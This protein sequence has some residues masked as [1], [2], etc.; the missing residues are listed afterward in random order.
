[1]TKRDA[2]NAW[3]SAGG[4]F[5]THEVAPPDAAYSSDDTQY[6]LF[7]ITDLVRRWYTGASPNHGVLFK[8]A[9]AGDYSNDVVEMERLR[10]VVTYLE[11]DTAAPE[12]DAGG[13]LANLEDRYTNG[14]SSPAVVVSAEDD[15]KGIAELNVSGATLGGLVLDCGVPR[16]CET[17]VSESFPVNLTGLAGGKH[18]L[19]ATARD[20]TNKV[21]VSEPWAILIDR[22]AP[23]VISD[24]DASKRAGQPAQVSWLEAD[25][26]D[27][28]DGNPGPRHHGL[29]LSLPPELGRVDGL[30]ADHT[31]DDH[32]LAGGGRGHDRRR[33]QEHRRRGQRGSRRVRHADRGAQRWHD[34]LAVPPSARPRVLRGAPGRRARQSGRVRVGLRRQRRHRHHLLQPDARPAAFQARVKHANLDNAVRFYGAVRCYNNGVDSKT[35]RLAA[36][37]GYDVTVCLY[38]VA[39]RRK[40]GDCSKRTAR[41]YARNGSRTLQLPGIIDVCTS[42]N[43]D[44]ALEAKS[45]GFGPSEERSS[46]DELDYTVTTL[47]TFDCNEPGAFRYVASTIDNEDPDRNP[48]GHWREHRHGSL[49]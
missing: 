1:M 28:P 3:A 14:Q 2:T 15:V 27:L 36:F 39:P 48:A 12:V 41:P 45:E 23:D 13:Q 43:H 20:D 4:D 47:Y 44:Y 7:E 11:P 35:R 46:A 24:V 18:V 42:G 38:S 17:E 29:L 31:P 19:H 6:G 22:Q 5:V 25:D 33:G 30:G 9:E 49:L 34:R 21:G 10:L 40:L 26:P 16:I 32:G 37:S 8:V